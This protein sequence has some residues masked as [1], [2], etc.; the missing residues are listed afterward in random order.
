MVKTIYALCIVP[1]RKQRAAPTN[2]NVHTR[3]QTCL[4]STLQHHKK[5]VFAASNTGRRVI[6]G[7][8]ALCAVSVVS[9]QQ[10][11]V[12]CIDRYVRTPRAGFV[13]RVPQRPRILSRSL[14]TTV[15]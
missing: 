14:N 1:S 9:D 2:R 8:A 13:L 3:A 12:A 10:Q 15:L 5:R 6:G 7:Q 11:R 4:P